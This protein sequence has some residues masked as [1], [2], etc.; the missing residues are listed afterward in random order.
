MD[1][2]FEDYTINRII[3]VPPA[4]VEKDE[5]V[6]FARKYDMRAFHLDEEFASGTRFEKL[7]A[8][9]FF[10]LCFAWS[11]WVKLDADDRGVVAGAGIDNLK[12][13]KPVYA[14]DTL[15]STLK[16]VDRME[17]SNG[18]NGIISMEFVTKNQ[19]GDIVLEAL[20]KHLARKGEYKDEK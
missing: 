4:V 20:V 15:T 12:W 18:K 17:S 5:M 16:V 6:E 3:E 9:G 13:T 7:F 19:N 14:G 10:T 2:Y 8:S 11:Q 1:L